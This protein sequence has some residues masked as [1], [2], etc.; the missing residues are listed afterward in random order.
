MYASRIYVTK[1]QRRPCLFDMSKRVVIIG[2]DYERTLPVLEELDR[3]G[4]R[5]E[6]WNVSKGCLVSTIPP[7]DD[8]IY[9]CRQSPSS[10][11][12]DHAASIPYVR[13]LL[14]WLHF[15]GRTVINGSHAFEAEMSKSAQMAIL[16]VHGINTPRTSLVATTR[17]L[18][19]ELLSGNIPG[20]VIL[21]PD[22]GGSGNG[23]QAFANCADAAYAVR[24]T[25]KD[26]AEST[27]WVVQE[28]LNAFSED[29]NR[30]RS[31]LRFEVIDSRVL[32]VMQIRAPVTVFKLCPC[33]PKLESLL[34]KV[35]F[36]IVTDPLTIPCFRDNPGSYQVFCD[37]ITGVWDMLGAKVGSVEAF[38][39]VEYADDFDGGTDEFATGPRSYSAESQ[40]SPGEPVVFEI[41]FN[42]NYNKT[43]E[44]MVGLSGA[45]EVAAML[46]R[47]ATATTKDNVQLPQTPVPRS[48]ST[49]PP[50]WPYHD[51][52]FTP[53]HVSDDSPLREL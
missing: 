11:A 46:A 5:V 52:V 45:A 40:I 10:G 2:E 47:L 27:L 34:S 38:L 1:L 12:R 39:P 29:V 26:V 33:D 20:P 31:I 25:W 13:N 51:T 30:M 53:V 48:P 18:V 16:N 32:Y 14:W 44:G 28:H 17:Q 19:V 36:R 23:V 3:L 49:P 4:I 15:H 24:H 37:K 35:E 8:A 50:M 42:S 21:K 43:A 22:T 9:F 6:M 7:P 41:N